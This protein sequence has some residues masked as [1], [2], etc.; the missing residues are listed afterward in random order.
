[1]KGYVEQAIGPNHPGRIRYQATY[2]FGICDDGRSL[3][4][5]AEVTVIGRR[6]NTLI[7]EPIS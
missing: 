5:G 2:W 3:P 6:G 7:V 1:M 4:R